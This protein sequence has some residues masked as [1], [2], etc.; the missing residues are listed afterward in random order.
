MKKSKAI[1]AHNKFA[2]VCSKFGAC[3]DRPCELLSI[4]AMVVYNTSKGWGALAYLLFDVIEHVHTF[5]VQIDWDNDVV[6]IAPVF[7]PNDLDL[8]PNDHTCEFDY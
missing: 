1:A 7:N 4:D 6:F 8:D 3:A 5:V 2:E